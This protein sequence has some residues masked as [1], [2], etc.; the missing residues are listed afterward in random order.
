MTGHD[1][2]GCDVMHFWDEKPTELNPFGQWSVSKQEE[3]KE[4]K[5]VEAV[6]EVTV[7]SMMG[8]FGGNVGLLSAWFD[9]DS[10]G[11]S[12]HL[13]SCGTARC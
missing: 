3:W 6:R 12:T 8:D 7:R 10:E 2:E 4:S 1:H 11:S 13:F 5:E 9:W